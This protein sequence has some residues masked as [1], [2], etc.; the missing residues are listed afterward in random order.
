MTQSKTTSIP[1]IYLSYSVYVLKQI[2]T[3]NMLHT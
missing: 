1:T 2:D 3:E